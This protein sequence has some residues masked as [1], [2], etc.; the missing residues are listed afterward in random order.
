MDRL[1]TKANFLIN[2]KAF[3]AYIEEQLADLSEVEKGRQ[4]LNLTTEVVPHTELGKVFPPP[5]QSEKE[6]HDEGI[7]LWSCTEDKSAY[8][9]IQARYTLN[10]VDQLDEIISKFQAYYTKYHVSERPQQLSFLN[11]DTSPQAE[12]YWMIVTLSEVHSLILPKYLSSHRPSK[13]FFTQHFE[14]KRFA[15]IDASKI[16]QIASEGWE[17]KF[18]DAPDL[19]LTSSAGWLTP[20]GNVY[21]GVVSS[22]ELQRLYRQAKEALFYENIRQFQG[23]QKGSVNVA[24][25]DTVTNQPDKLIQ[26][27]NGIVLRAK[28]VVRYADDDHTIH[29]EQASIVNGVQTTTVVSDYAQNE[30][31]LLV[32]VVETD[33]SWDVTNAANFQNTIHRIDLDIAKYMRPQMVE[34]VSYPAGVMIEDY[35]LD[36]VGSILGAIAR[37]RIAYR[38]VRFLF[39]GLFSES[40]SN[41]FKS[42][43]DEIETEV[44]EQFYAHNQLEYIYDIIFQIYQV[45]NQGIKLVEETYDKS[46]VDVLFKRLIDENKSRYVQ[47]LIILSACASAEIDISDRKS[48][49]TEEEYQRM[50]NFF[51]R[52]KTILD[53]D[54]NQISVNFLRAYQTIVEGLLVKHKTADEVRRFMFST[55]KNTTFSNLFNAVRMKIQSEALIRKRL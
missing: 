30:C 7:D 13:D 25:R 45:G 43:Y 48:D 16:F 42:Q 37:T 40:P 5:E 3:H 18:G 8:L 53:N 44:L 46:M 35:K 50:L 47:Y 6:S 32:K 1:S 34:K 17:Y 28:R 12:I 20:P 33:E 2:E 10:R 54:P 26:L 31:H 22:S 4:W 19:T 27:N 24:I 21:I 52:L 15:I 55:I 9:Y 51:S 23:Y 29:L 41:V 38:D 36:K 14:A 11:A 49:N 39:I